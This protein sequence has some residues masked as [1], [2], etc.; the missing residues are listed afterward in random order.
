ML[1]DKHPKNPSSDNE[2]IARYREERDTAVIGE[3]FNRYT[4][5]VYG[6]CMQYLKD[7]DAAKDATM[8]IFEKL[9]ADLLK[10]TILNFKSWLLTVCR[11][12]CLMFLRAQRPEI[13]FDDEGIMESMVSIHHEEDP[14]EARQ[15]EQQLQLLEACLE[16]LDEDQRR[17]I[18][19]FYLK[20]LSYQTI[21]TQTGFTFKQV[22]S[23]LQNGH[24]ESLHFGV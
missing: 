11:N 16:K 8:Q 7:S 20:R 23:Y 15:T 6:V 14:F 1:T 3:L 12:H 17:C 4:H 18:D 22:K 13:R 19:Y 24:P 5:L 9:P 10:H 21:M 2:L